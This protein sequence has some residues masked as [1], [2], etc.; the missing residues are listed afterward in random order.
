M[1]M[2]S[3]ASGSSGNCI[4]AGSETTH[5]LIDA[6]ISGKR[7][8]EGLAKLDLS[9]RDIDGIF[10]THEHIDHIQ[11]LGVLLRKYRIPVYCTEG[12][13]RGILSD[14]RIGKVDESLIQVVAEDKKQTVK[15][16]TI[17]P[18][19]ISHDAAQ[20]VA[21]KICHGKQNGAVV[22]D[23]GVYN[24]Y[25]VEHLKGVNVLFL[26]ANHDV[27][28][29]QVG[30]YP[31]PLKRRILGERGHLS[32]EMAGKLLCRI[33]HDNLKAIVLSHLSKEN[34]LPELAYETVRTEIMMSAEITMSDL[35]Y[36]GGDFPLYVAKRSEVSETIC[37]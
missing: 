33:L 8:E 29:L 6:G 13:K 19:R 23:L 32:N 20:P 34:N 18:I 4:Y 11:G 14:G 9:M 2:C 31:Y 5:L 1:R 28:M 25:I 37:I 36:R 12:T 16:I 17:T 10:I 27:N 26:E 21:Y 15:D 24:D 7:T 3:I 35:S 30:P 22:T